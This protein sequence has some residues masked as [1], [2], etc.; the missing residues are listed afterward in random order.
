MPPSRGLGRIPGM[1]HI[2]IS[3][4]PWITYWTL[5]GIGIPLGVAIS[6]IIS[7]SLIVLQLP[8][9]ELSLM[10]AVSLIYFITASVVTF[11]LSSPLFVERSGFLGY[12]TLFLMAVISLVIKKPYTLQVSKRDYP[13]IYW[14]ERSFML[15]NE[16]ITMFWAAIFLIN[17]FIYLIVGFPTTIVISNALIAIGI[18]FSIWLPR[19]APAYLASRE[20]RKYDWRVEFRGRGEHDAIIVGS[21][22]GGLTC[23]AMLSKRGYRV[24]V[25][26]QHHQVGGYCSSFKRKGFV[27]NVGVED[28]S[29]L[30]ERRP[31]THLLRELGF[32]KED[33]FVENTRRYV[34]K[35]EEIDIPQDPEGIVRLLSRDVSG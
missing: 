15:V 12:L 9:G 4:I 23:G 35:G 25:L 3:F 21:G 10:D 1:I 14:R 32:K 20:F 33:L 8:R 11:T 16:M 18:A 6:L 7:S 13:E 28:V 19:A 31:V 27:F 29:G 17:S 5:C 26:E 22:I 30:W 24:L 2:L 34:L